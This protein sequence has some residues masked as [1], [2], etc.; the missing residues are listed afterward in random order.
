MIEIGL[1]TFALAWV[2]SLWYKVDWLRERLGVSF[3][4][5]DTGEPLDRVDEGGLGAWLNC[6]L[7][8]AVL[9]LPIAVLL[10]VF[11]EPGSDALAGL[12]VAILAMR[13]FEGLRP[14][15]RWWA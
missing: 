11:C 10:R 15:A 3:Y 9:C 5:D 7:C 12:G 2:L 14:K 13:W 8:A 1:G 4:Y 6:P